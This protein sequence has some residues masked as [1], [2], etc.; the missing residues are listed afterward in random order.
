MLILGKSYVKPMTGGEVEVG[1]ENCHLFCDMCTN[2][3]CYLDIHVL[4]LR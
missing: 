1:T 3:V 2:K 4:A